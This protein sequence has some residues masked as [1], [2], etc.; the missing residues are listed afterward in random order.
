MGLKPPRFARRH[1]LGRLSAM[2]ALIVNLKFS[3]ITPAM[4]TRIEALAAE[5]ATVD[6]L[7]S[8]CW[9]RGASRLT[10][11]QT[12]A[13]HAAVNAYLDGPLFSALGRLP[14]CQDVFAAL[15]DVAT[16]LNA[17]SVLGAPLDDPVVRR[18]VALA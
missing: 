18:E 7:L 13:S 10:L 16:N 14:A 4:S 17:L 8:T 2:R 9:L 5:L 12:F 11:V 15:Y 3:E 6:G 1:V